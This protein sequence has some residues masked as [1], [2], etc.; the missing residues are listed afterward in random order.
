MAPQ[1]WQ[2]LHRSQNSIDA[3][4]NQNKPLF[5]LIALIA[6][7]YGLVNIYVDSGLARTVCNAISGVIVVYGLLNRLMPKNP[8]IKRLNN[9]LK[10]TYAFNILLDKE[11]KEGITTGDPFNK[12]KARVISYTADQINNRTAL[13]N[14][15]EVFKFDFPVEY[16]FY[17]GAMPENRLA[18][19]KANLNSQFLFITGEAGGGKTFE[20][21]KRVHYICEKLKPG[22][23]VHHLLKDQKI[24]IYIELKSLNGELDN[25]WIIDYI[26]KTASIANHALNP[27]QVTSLIEHGQVVYF[28]DGLDE[29]QG[30]LRGKCVCQLVELATATGVHVT[31]RKEIFRELIDKKVLEANHK[32]AEFFLKSISQDWINEII[33]EVPDKS[34]AEKAEMI[35]FIGGKPGLLTHMARPIFLNLF[36]SVYQNLTS[37]QKELLESSDEDKTMDVLWENYEDII[38]RKKLQKDSDMLGIRTI[39][40]WL[41]KIM[42]GASFYVESIQPYWLFKVDQSHVVGHKMLQK[43]Y[44][45]AT[46]ILAAAII[47]IAFG[48]II[49]TPFA[50]LSGSVLAG[51]VIS[52]LAGLYDRKI[53]KFRIPAWLSAFLFSLSMIVLLT[54]VCG[55][56]QGFS[57]PRAHEEMANP[58]FSIT[59]TWPGILLGMILSIIFTYRIILEKRKKQYILPIELFHFDWSHAF[60]YGLSW[61]LASGVITGI[62]ALIVRHRYTHTVFIST[63]LIPRLEKMIAGFGFARSDMNIDVAIFSYA[64]VVTFFVASGIVI[65][66][67][68]RYNDPVDKNTKNKQQLNYGIRK[69]GKHAV[70]HAFKVALLGGALY[71]ATMVGFG[72][73]SLFYCAKISIGISILA[74]LWFGGMEVINHI[75]LRVNLYIRG[76]APLNY[77]PWVQAQQNMGLIIPTGYQLKFYHASLAGYYARYSLTDNPRIRLPR[78][79]VADILLYAMLMSAALALLVLPFLLRYK[80]DW[81]W[82]RPSEFA[83]TFRGISKVN[84]STYVIEKTG[85]YNV[86]TSGYISAGTFTGYSG[87]EGTSYGFMGMPMEGAYNV[88]GFAKFRHAA[89][90]LQ[91]KKRNEPWSGYWYVFNVKR[92]QGERGQLLQFLIND[93]EW[94]NNSGH[95]NVQMTFCDSCIHQ[96]PKL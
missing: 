15:P 73:G 72:R 16:D 54:V 4:K 48:C 95:Y 49:A 90:L 55:S 12:F 1:Q 93:N 64:F 75:I 14:S 85:I 77:D 33:R 65:L 29:V 10:K 50:L 89:L 42:S 70:V 24:P 62:I 84:D 47:G 27:E 76:I 26:L 41:A 57:V 58:V 91:T 34:E 3:M 92:F 79:K 20:L 8:L 96:T 71:Y 63:W 78:K 38:Y 83:S 44:F 61:G 67:A 28:F 39:T 32:P 40:V 81:Y 46:R 52:L 86:R 25:D 74:F 94:Q 66:L 37:E 35:E 5:Y 19:W 36:I 88:P 68:G 11:E 2:L 13:I 87:P 17:P 23:E 56:Y 80:F 30:T 6:V 43:L 59:E 53:K 22:L 60:R 18:D 45:L 69:S 51:I 7:A 31:C 21:I 9:R 82:K